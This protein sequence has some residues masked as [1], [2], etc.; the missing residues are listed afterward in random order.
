M[1]AKT[2]GGEGTTPVTTA[3]MS[4]SWKVEVYKKNTHTR[5]DDQST[6]SSEKRGTSS[7]KQRKNVCQLRINKRP[8]A[9]D[10]QTTTATESG[11]TATTR[12]AILLSTY[13]HL[14]VAQLNNRRNLYN[15]TLAMLLCG[16]SG[17]SMKS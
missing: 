1:K 14:R 17:R 3:R 7:T 16:F 6:I 15:T 5:K 8:L 9:L 12:H 10:R 2:R 11:T 13:H 4:R